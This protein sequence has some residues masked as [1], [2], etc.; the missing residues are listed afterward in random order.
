MQPSA[1]A[2]PEGTPSWQNILIEKIVVSN[3]Q[4]SGMVCGV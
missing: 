3:D 2:L 4:S 1:K